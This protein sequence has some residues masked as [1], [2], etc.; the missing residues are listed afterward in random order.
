MLFRS[1]GGLTID[2]A[3]FDVE[4]SKSLGGNDRGPAMAVLKDGTVI[5]GGG[6]RGGTIFAWDE[7]TQDL[8]ILGEMM[9]SKERIRDSRFAITDIA[10]LA[11]NNQSANLLISY[12]R[13]GA[14]RC[15]EV[16]VFR[17]T[18]NRFCDKNYQK[19]QCS[20]EPRGTVVTKHHFVKGNHP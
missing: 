9:K 14:S 5:L 8:K 12:P 18:F 20:K 17:A 1:V 19:N 2:V 6:S 11:E 16:V 10:I 4:R 13:L 15:V 3:S 7:E